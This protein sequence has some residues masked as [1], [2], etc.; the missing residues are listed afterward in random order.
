M[1]KSLTLQ[2]SMLC[3][4]VSQK[5]VKCFAELTA[6]IDNSL[7]KLRGNPLK[8]SCVNKLFQTSWVKLYGKNLNILQEHSC[9]GPTV[10]CLQGVAEKV[11]I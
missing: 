2:S 8:M 7:Q 10:A 11:T 3:F 9:Q 4:E 1:M 6:Q 5:Q